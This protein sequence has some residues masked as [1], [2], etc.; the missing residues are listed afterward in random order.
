MSILTQILVSLIALEHFGFLYMEMF[1]WTKPFGLKTFN[2]T[3]EQAATTKVLAAN[4]GLYN[5]FLATGL[6]LSMISVD[7]VAQVFFLLCVIVAGI[8]GAV[9]VKRSIFTYQ[10]LPA[11]VALGLLIFVTM[12]A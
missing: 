1:L 5:G 11:I 3:A 7:F 2:M 4:Q 12:N 10:A 9:T 8:F 6:A